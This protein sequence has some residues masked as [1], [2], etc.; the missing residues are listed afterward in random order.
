VP[1]IF[2]ILILLIFPT[3]SKASQV[4]MYFA[5]FAFM[6]NYENRADLYPYASQFMANKDESL[7]VKKALM[8]VVKGTV[9]KNINIITDRL[10]NLKSGSDQLTITFGLSSEKVSYQSYHGGFLVKC[11]VYSTVMVFDFTQ[12]KVIA[13]Y[14][15]RVEFV[16]FLDAKPDSQELRKIFYNMYTNL[17]I[18]SSVFVNWNKRLVDLNVKSE[19]G[20]YIKV[21]SVK[22]STDA[23]AMLGG[24]VDAVESRLAQFL[25]A[26]LSDQFQ[27]PL[28]PFTKGEAI[29]GSVPARF[30]DM[31]SFNFKLPV[32][33]YEINVV[34]PELKKVVVNSKGVIQIIYASYLEVSVFQPDLNRV[35]SSVRV[36]NTPVATLNKHSNIK[37]SDSDEFNKSIEGLLNQF[38]RQIEKRDRDWLQKSTR[39]IHVKKKLKKIESIILSAG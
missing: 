32:A 18:K 15:A 4:D 25:E 28:L 2:I 29:G 17:N 11:Q 39:T 33:D 34:I 31:S 1:A 12:K 7:A 16:D 38:S 37:L 19:Y 13:N 21:N 30:S 6:G 36:R 14:P 5:G 20:N 3:L 27:I 10:A 35:L 22:L 24:D 9:Y 8:S 26:S 23:A